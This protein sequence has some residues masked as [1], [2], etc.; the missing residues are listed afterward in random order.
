MTRNIRKI[1]SIICAVALL[2][3]L[4]VVSLTGSSSAKVEENGNLSEA[5]MTEVVNL[6]FQG[7]KP[8]G[9]PL[10]R[11]TKDVAYDTAN[12][13][14]KVGISSGYIFF[15]KDGSVGNPTIQHNDSVTQAVKDSAKDNLYTLQAG[16]TYEVSFA[17]KFLA[18]TKVKTGKQAYVNVGIAANPLTGGTGNKT[19]MNVIAE[20]GA[21]TVWTVDGSA[22]ATD[23]VLTVDSDWQTFTRT[24]T[25][26]TDGYIGIQCFYGDGAPSPMEYFAIDDFCIKMASG[27]YGFTKVTETFDTLPAGTSNNSSTSTIVE[28]PDKGSVLKVTASGNARMGFNKTKVINYGNKY[29]ISFDAKTDNACPNFNFV[30]GQKDRSGDYR[31]FLSGCGTELARTAEFYIDGVKVSNYNAFTPNNE[32]RHYTMVLDFDKSV[33]KAQMD[34]AGANRLENGGSTYLL[35]GAGQSG[36]NKNVYYD[37]L[38]IVTINQSAEPG[39]AV[40][41]KVVDGKSEFVATAAGQVYPLTAPDNNDPDRGFNCW[42]DEAGNEIE[43]PGAFTPSKGKT[44][45]TA[46]WTAQFVKVTYVNGSET[47]APVR[48]A[49]GAKLDNPTTRINVNLFFQQWEDA[50]GNVYT[51]APDHNVT[52]YAKYSGTY[53]GFDKVGW[54]GNSDPGKCEIVPDPADA[55][56]SVLK[57][58]TTNVDRVMF[59]LPAGDYSGAGAFKLKTNTTYFYTIKYKLAAGATSGDLQFVRGNSCIYKP[60]ST[61]RTAIPGVPVVTTS[62]TDV[63]TDWITLTGSFTTGDSHY[64]E[65]V[66]WFYQDKLIISLQRGK[67]I[68]FDDIVIAEVL[69]EAPEGTHAIE[70]KTNGPAVNTIYG[71]PGDAVVIPDN[72]QSSSGKFLGWYTDKKLTVPYTAT[73]F[74]NEDITLYAKWE[75]VP[76]LM[77]VENYENYSPA[78][79]FKIEVDANGN[80]YLNRNSEFNP[81][82]SIDI[83]YCMPINANGVRYTVTPGVSYKVTFK[84]KMISG[85]LTVGVV[86]NDKT[87]TWASRQE[88]GVGTTLSGVNKDDWKTASF[89]F[90]ASCPAN[91][92]YISFGVAGNGNCYFDDIVV[93]AETNMMNLYGSTIIYLNSNGG[94]AMNPISGDPGEA[95]G[96][97]PKPVKAG[98]AFEGWYTDKE[99]TTKFTDKAFGEEGLTLYANYILGKFTE[100]YED[101]PS[102]VVATGLAG[103]YKIYNSTN[104]SGSFDKANVQNGSVSI[105]RN[106]SSTGTK[107]FTLCRDDELALTVGKQYTVTFYVKPTNV[108]QAAGTISLINMPK[109]ATGINTPT[110]T[111]VI[112]TV[113]DL[114]AGEWQKVSYTFTAKDKYL[115]I[116]T[117]AGND[118]YFDNFTVTLKGY[119]GTSTG[120][121]SVNPLLIVMMVVLAAG[122]LIVTGKKVFEK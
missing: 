79:R 120:D 17:Y 38:E 16:K 52:L 18:G 2:L 66:N 46:K 32:W 47:S 63:D 30:L 24:F 73:E 62:A 7:E 10:G 3:S 70:F 119:S 60:G 55:T 113:G 65:R 50:D 20:S 12:G 91:L 110:S 8:Y 96:E 56:N 25:A 121:T 93:E 114:K 11:W 80:H 106:G 48:L 37:N 104:F 49:V 115:G 13:Y 27:S 76:F 36:G 116:S 74:G 100:S 75:P 19:G 78:S 99:C 44:T 5:M 94:S 31:I 22:P 53:L 42:V 105:F 67:Q 86:Y 95:I 15:G 85:N 98:Y 89:T 59:E 90:T 41:E 103:G 58:D 82:Q 81:G 28:D 23:T 101:F 71:Y 77:D 40:I 6:T 72:I 87:S 109:F 57:V 64:L 1:V 108:T 51:E 43:N 88:E 107:A 35:L 14:A 21:T 4:S 54:A 122:A 83:H 92:N 111:D 61:V 33:W 26:T 34:Y 102:N 97:L 117:T 84:Y 69:D 112:T 118:M 29:Y 39:T 9:I 45:V 68:Y